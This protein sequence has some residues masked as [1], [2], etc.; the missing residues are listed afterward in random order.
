[1]SIRN[2]ITAAAVIGTLSGCGVAPAHADAMP[3]G[4]V[5]SQVIAGLSINS[6]ADP[7]PWP[8][9]SAL[10]SWRGAPASW[11][12]QGLDAPGNGRGGGGGGG[13]SD[14]DGD[15]RGASCERG[16]ASF[17]PRPEPPTP[18]NDPPGVPGPAGALGAAATWGWARRLRRRV[19]NSLKY[20]QRKPMAHE[21]VALDAAILNHLRQHPKAHPVSSPEIRKLAAQT[22]QCRDGRLPCRVIDARMKALR[23]AGLQRWDR[24]RFRYVVQGC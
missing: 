2:H 10:M 8:A 20:S 16:N 15:G 14:T 13:T 7:R 19:G 11:N 4:Y 17:C 5:S 23:E 21:V 3:P 18:H 12:P 6:P 22:E 9:P 24:S 1:M